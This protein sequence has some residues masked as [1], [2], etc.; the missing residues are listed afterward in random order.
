MR[1]LR[2]HEAAAEEAAE[3]EAWYGKERPGLGKEFERVID[4]ALDLLEEAIVPLTSMSGAAGTRGVRRLILRRFPTPSS[5]PSAIQ[6]FSLLRS[7]TTQGV[8]V[9]GA[10]GYGPKK[11][12]DTFSR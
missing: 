1:A 2:I 3:A 11:V 4:A 5:S 10:I 8:R 7:L 9:T 12:P 6:K